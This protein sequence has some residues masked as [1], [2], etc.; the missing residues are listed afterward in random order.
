MDNVCPVCYKTTL[1]RNG[2]LLCPTAFYE[3]ELAAT[4]I[5]PPEVGGDTQLGDIPRKAT[6]MA[7]TTYLSHFEPKEVSS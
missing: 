3:A 5:K 6:T 7:I 4:S 2:M 1:S